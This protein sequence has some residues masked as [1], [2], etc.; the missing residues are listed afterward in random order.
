M[1][2]SLPTAAPLA[3]RA[4]AFTIHILTASGAAFAL[5]A[6]MLAT[7]SEWSAMFFVL[8]LALIVDAIDGPLA[9][10]FNVVEL[11]PRWSGEGLDYVVDFVTYVFVPAFAVA[12]SG[13]MPDG[14]AI[15][16]GVLIV[17]TGALYFADRTMK[18]DGNYFRGFPALWNAAAFYLF[19]LRP[20]GWI[21]LAI[22]VILAGL[23]FAPIRFLHPVRVTQWRVITMPLLALW[24][25]LAA[26]AVWTG[27][28]PGRMVT[29][30]LCLIA[31]YFFLAGYLQRVI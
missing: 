2:E 10:R 25:V 29:L 12:A 19:L 28:E 27:L 9:R 13:L 20:P 5:V 3:T 15:P 8:G 16:A 7:L 1:P 18:L 14:F 24:A 17:I 23:T 22:V 4:G 6:A 21:A 30:P 26:I 11:L 31:V